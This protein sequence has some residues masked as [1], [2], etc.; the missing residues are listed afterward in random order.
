L[1]SL[2]DEVVDIL[3]QVVV[4]LRGRPPVKVLGNFAWRISVTSL[5]Q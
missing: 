1:S 2:L 4:V 3:H 5:W